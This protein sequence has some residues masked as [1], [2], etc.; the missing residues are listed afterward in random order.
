MSKWIEVYLA[1]GRYQQYLPKSHPDSPYHYIYHHRV[2]RGIGLII[3]IVL[4]YAAYELIDW[5]TYWRDIGAWIFFGAVGIAI[6]FLALYAAINII[7]WLISWL[8]GE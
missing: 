6:A 2:N 3:S 1:K 8:K 5:K 4:A 7:G